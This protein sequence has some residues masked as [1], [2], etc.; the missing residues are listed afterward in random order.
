MNETK[1]EVEKRQK[2][3][4][5]LNLMAII[6]AA[7]LVFSVWNEASRNGKQNNGPIKQDYS[8]RIYDSKIIEPNYSP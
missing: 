1:K 7:G 5:P 8:K 3:G 2:L 4:W 6:S